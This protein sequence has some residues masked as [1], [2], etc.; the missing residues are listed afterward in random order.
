LLP[1]EAAVFQDEVDLNLNPDIGCTW[2]RRG[3][4]ARVV[5]PGTMKG[6]RIHHLAGPEALVYE[7]APV[8]A[9]RP[10]VALFRVHA[11]A[12]SPAE[13][14]WR[15]YET[16]DERSRVAK[17]PSHEMSGVVVAVAPDVCDAAV[18]C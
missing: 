9:L 5:T 3:E 2:M 17:I 16:P 4:Q 15:I 10:G 8:P 12:T 6:I 13:F 11:A 7:D 14:T 1:D 18:A